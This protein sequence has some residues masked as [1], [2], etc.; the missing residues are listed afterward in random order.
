MGAFLACRNVHLRKVQFFTAKRSEKRARCPHY[1]F[2][3]LESN[4]TDVHLREV[5][6]FT[7]VWSLAARMCTYGRCNFYSGLESGGLETR[8]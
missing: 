2:G 4:G 7:E 3:S 1:E 5:Q 6:F 8:V